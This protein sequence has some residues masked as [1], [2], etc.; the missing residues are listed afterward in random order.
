[1]EKPYIIMKD[2]EGDNETKNCLGILFKFIK[3]KK[4]NIFGKNN[5]K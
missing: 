3:D 1:M 5:N 2:K 4:I